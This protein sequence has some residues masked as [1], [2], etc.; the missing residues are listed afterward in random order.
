M[1]DRRE[2]I[3]G[4][5]LLEALV[6]PV[7][8]AAESR[9]AAATPPAF[10][11]PAAVPASAP[12]EP[13][14]SNL[15]ALIT[16]PI[17]SSIASGF[18]L[19]AY[20][21]LREPSVL[22]G[23]LQ[24]K[25]PEW[26]DEHVGDAG[27]TFALIVPAQLGMLVTALIFALP[28]RENV[29]RRLGFVRGTASARTIAWAVLGTLGVQFAISCVADLLIDDYSESLQKIW[30][31]FS[32]PTGVAAVLVGLLMSVMPG[33]CEESLFRG[34]SQR[35]L[36]RRWRPFT[37]ILVASAAFA[38]AHLDWQHS[39]AVFPLGVWFGI[40]A[41]RTG[42]IWPSIAC[43]FANNA[44]AFVVGRMWGDPE[45]GE[46]RG[47]A[48]YY[49][50]GVVFLVCTVVA[51]FALARTRPPEELAPRTVVAA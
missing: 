24:R 16:A 15:L 35:G 21:A 47:H 40:V 10:G 26:I 44:F 23:D 17:A 4:A 6:P 19:V 7:I 18:A 28:S 11:V 34:C 12:R 1:S 13:I 33:I 42:S 14:W 48:L 37:A 3:P 51:S 46:V 49:G 20:V 31:M 25:L 27:L 38:L 45:S 50:S 2:E 39:P 32:V 8:G 41:W 43:H 9:I 30:K 22:R 5:P 36:L 29:F